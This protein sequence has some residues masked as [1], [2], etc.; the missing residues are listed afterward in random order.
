VFEREL[1]TAVA[2][3][4]TND[5]RFST[6]V[7]LDRYA[8]AMQAAE[9]MLEFFH[10]QSESFSMPCTQVYDTSSK[11]PSGIPK[12]VSQVCWHLRDFSKMGFY[13]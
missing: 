8:Y 3:A 7:L 12:T 10:R 1:S 13:S 11:P 6:P 4:I 2:G 5:L 9:T